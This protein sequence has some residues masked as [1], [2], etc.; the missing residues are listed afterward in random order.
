MPARTPYLK[1]QT[2]PGGSVVTPDA[3]R[4]TPNLRVRNARVEPPPASPD[5]R[6]ARVRCAGTSPGV[7]TTIAQ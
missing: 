5:E 6:T 3:T 4:Y 7:D 1:H 2:G